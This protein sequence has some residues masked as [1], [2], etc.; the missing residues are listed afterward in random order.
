MTFKNNTEEFP[1]FNHEK[2]I[3][4]NIATLRALGASKAAKA[5]NDLILEIAEK[6]TAAFE[7]HVGLMHEI[8][9][10]VEPFQAQPA[11]VHQDPLLKVEDPCEQRTS[12][13]EKFDKACEELST[14]IEAMRVAREATA[15]EAMKNAN[16]FM[17]STMNDYLIGPAYATAE[18]GNEAK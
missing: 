18:Q 7:L 16:D 3:A 10:R 17:R 8:L 1:R 5:Q 2:F 14:I 13:G 6:S 9:N 4:L 11:E 12:H 15:K